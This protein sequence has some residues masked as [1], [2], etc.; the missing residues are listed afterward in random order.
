MPAEKISLWELVVVYIFSTNSGTSWAAVNIGLTNYSI[1]AFA[2]SGTNIFAGTNG[3]VYS[4][5]IMEPGG[6]RPIMDN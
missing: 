2:V 3:G 5:Q 1:S 6:L 4:Q